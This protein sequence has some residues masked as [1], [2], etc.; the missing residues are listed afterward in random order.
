MTLAASCSLACWP[1][2]PHRFCRVDGPDLSRHCLPDDYFRDSATR[3]PYDWPRATS[4]LRGVGRPW[5]EICFRR[6]QFIVWRSC[7]PIS[8]DS[9]RWSTVGLGHA[10][11]VATDRFSGDFHRPCQSDFESA[12]AALS[13][14]CCD[15]EP[16]SV[17]DRRALHVANLDARGPRRTV[18]RSR[19]H[20]RNLD[21]LFPYFADCD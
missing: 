20:G 11:V 16:G 13:Q 3:P 15:T 8:S 18:A 12:I 7:G 5:A 9:G 21:S 4:I 19:N 6:T 2:H 14:V 17:F 1:P 10:V